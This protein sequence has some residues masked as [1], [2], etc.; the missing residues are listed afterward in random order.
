MNPIDQ[1]SVDPAQGAATTGA[2]EAHAS[3]WSWVPIRSLGPRHHD[4]IVAHLLSLEES[5][6]YLRFGYPATDAQIARY[7]DTL[8]FDQDEVFGVFNRRLELIAMAHLAHP[9]APADPQ[10]GAMAEFGVSV[11]RKARGRGF[12]ARLFEHS[13]LH[14]RNRGVQ[15]LFIHALSENTAMLKI[16]R[17]AG[18][19]VER[20]GSESD[21]WLR[22]PPDTFV[23]HVEEMMGEQAAEFDY[24]L[25]RHAS[26]VQRILDTIS[27]VKAHISKSHHIAGE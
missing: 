1:V 6:R 4:R 14:A 25:K 9:N 24:Q 21:A 20:D 7:V 23:S 11:V 12:G 13:V 17:N 3:Q 16:A 8:D 22:L 2:T 10:R 15:T 5:D 18:A 26:Q 27:E 19:T